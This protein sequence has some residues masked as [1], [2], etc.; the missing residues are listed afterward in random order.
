M[1]RRGERGNKKPAGCFFKDLAK[2]WDHRLF[3]WGATGHSCVRRIG[4]QS[5]HAFVTDPFQGFQIVWRSYNR[6]VVDLVIASMDHRSQ[7]SFDR[8]RKTIDERMRRVNKLDREI[9]DL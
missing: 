9:P 4:K 7:R 2:R 6:G 1:N 8:K 5:K 3:G